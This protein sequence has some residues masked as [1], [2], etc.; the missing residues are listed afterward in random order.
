MKQNLG[1][2]A[3]AYVVD[4]DAAIRTAVCELLESA[5]IQTRNFSSA[6]EF[7]EFW[8]PHMA[9]CLVL[10]VRLPGMSGMALQR[11]LAESGI[12]LPIIIMTGHGDVPMVKEAL[13]AGAIEFLT[14]PF[15]D[16]ELLRAVEQAFA[17]D[18]AR[19]Q[20]DLLVQSIQER[21]ESLTEREHQIMHLV[22]AGLTNREIAEKF[23]VSLVTVKLHRGQVMRKMR[24][25]SLA[26]L[27]KMSEKVRESNSSSAA[28]H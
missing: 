26:D 22:T 5:E 7:A 24:A 14:K 15:P 19:R 25:D 23:S 1:Y 9:G 13:K 27:V 11:Q 6:E 4:D 3:T 28:R 2:E 20:S 17:V 18:R 8:E 16:E 21:V 10:D 12:A